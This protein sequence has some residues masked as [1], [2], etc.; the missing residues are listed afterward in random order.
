MTGVLHLT[1]ELPRNTCEALKGFRVIE[2]GK[3][4][5]LVNALARID[6]ALLV[7]ARSSVYGLR[8]RR[9]S[10]KVLREIERL[11]YQSPNELIFK[12][13]LA[14][15]TSFIKAVRRLQMFEIE[16]YGGSQFEL[17][18]DSAHSIDSA[19]SISSLSNSHGE[20]VLLSGAGHA[21]ASV[22]RS[23]IARCALEFWTREQNSSGGRFTSLF[24][25]PT[26]K[27]LRE[28]FA[29]D[30]PAITKLCRSEGFGWLPSA[31]RAPVSKASSKLR[32]VA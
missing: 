10:F 30:E 3:V 1:T 11:V 23:R 16:H 26:R 4:N 14:R 9:A 29:L 12:A 2:N 25:V 6:T 20:E 22:P 24:Y 32:K 15:F 28:N 21:F 13:Q 31:S 5:P 8:S 17:S 27:E 19:Q 18:F 7:S